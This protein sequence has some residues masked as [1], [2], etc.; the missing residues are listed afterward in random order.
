LQKKGKRDFKQVFEL[1]SRGIKRIEKKVKE[2]QIFNS[3]E[4]EK[5]KPEIGEKI[6][7]VRYL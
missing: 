2:I 1:N 7:L 5:Q 6:G 4:L 3:Q